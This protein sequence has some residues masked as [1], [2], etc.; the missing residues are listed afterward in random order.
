M[1]DIS[2]L[3]NADNVHCH[4]DASSRK[5]VLQLAA[6]LIG[7]ATLPAD[8]LFDALMARERLGSTGLG[9]GIAIPHCRSDCDAM[10]VGFI[11]LATPIDYEAS[12]GEDVDLLFILVVPEDEQHAHL[13]ALA[14]LAEV[15]SDAQ[16]RTDLR[17][18][19]SDA[20]LLKQMQT[21]LANQ[22]PDSRTA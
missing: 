9:D 4:V 1:S 10:R 13:H 11:S 21:C 17:S 6:E 3:I 7:D 12:D 14:Q 5:R 18:C 8:T 16:N 2:A 20:A 19:T 15:F 22:V